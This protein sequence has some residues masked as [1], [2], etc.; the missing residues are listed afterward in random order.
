MTG[1]VVVVSGMRTNSIPC[2]ILDKSKGGVL[3]WLERAEEVPDDFYLVFDGQSQK[4]TCS[5]ARRGRKYLG[6]RFVPQTATAAVR[7]SRT[8]GF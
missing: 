5:V 4:I 3:L 2:Q 1:Q 6:V 8:S 7:T